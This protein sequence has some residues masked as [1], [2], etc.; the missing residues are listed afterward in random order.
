MI[1][2]LQ[3]RYH[4][5]RVQTHHMTG[6]AIR[7]TCGGGMGGA[8]WSRY[9]V[10][11]DMTDPHFIK[12]IDLTN[13]EIM[14]GKNFVVEYIACDFAGQTV[15]N[16][17]RKTINKRCTKRSFDREYTEWYQ[18]QKG[19]GKHVEWKTKYPVNLN[20]ELWPKPVAVIHNWR[21]LAMNE[22]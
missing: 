12:A 11:M 20:H 17:E 4:Q 7:M 9:V 18:I 16:A 8:S 21:S 14:I 1:I 3:P 19:H 13:S 5:V 10:S 15:C 22:Q 6:F 2:A